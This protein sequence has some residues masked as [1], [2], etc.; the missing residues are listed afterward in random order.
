MA[1]QLK[2]ELSVVRGGGGHDTGNGSEP[3]PLDTSS[4]AFNLTDL[5]NAERFVAQHG[6][7]VHYVRTMDRWLVWDGVRWVVDETGSVDRLAKDTVRSIYREAGRAKGA[8]VR[9]A[10][11]K[12]ALASEA[13]GRI[14]AMLERARAET[15][16][17]RTLADFDAD[18]WRLNVRNGCLDLRTGRLGAHDR[19]ARCRKLADVPYEPHDPHC[20]TWERFLDRILGGDAA[21]IAFVRRA[22]GYSLTGQA[23]EQC[24]FFL[25]GRGA[26][27]KSTFLEILRAL[28][29]EY[30]VQSEF[31]TLAE[32]K[33]DSGP[34]ND[35]ARLERARLVVASELGEGKRLNEELVKSL[36]GSDTIT[37]R[38]LHQEHF[39][40]RPEFKL[41]L[42]ANHKPVIRGT[43]DGIWRRVRL[44]PFEVQIPEAE[45]DRTLLDRLRGELPGIL[46][47]AVAGCLEWQ[48]CGL[49]PPAVVRA[50]TQQYREES[51]VLGAWIGENCVLGPTCAAPSNLLYANYKRWAELGGEYVMSQTAFGRRLQERGHGVEKR[52]G[53][54]KWR[55]GVKLGDVLGQL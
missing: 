1:L 44:I 34:R 26:N 38:F 18:P 54:L 24:L 15:G 23:T 17:A 42:A 29:G 27:G 50:A 9:T 37:A 48:Q 5:G 46:A 16:V 12:W 3:P 6:E 2:P 20:A 52:P 47:W 53:G 21:L 43:D 35:V 30:A 33:H 31:S 45:Q 28:L 19:E 51:D 14:K 10:L 22:V 39:E 25:H 36:T 40:F 32:R 41:W 4:V 13:N 11:A 8:K 49:Q 7:Q 55:V